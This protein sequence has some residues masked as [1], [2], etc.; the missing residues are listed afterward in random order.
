M[1]DLDLQHAVG[2]VAVRQALWVGVAVGVAWVLARD[3]MH[4][5]SV[6]LDYVRTEP[7]EHSAVHFKTC[8]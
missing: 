7:T 8:L 1:T 2:I 3:D 5:S 4:P 6:Y